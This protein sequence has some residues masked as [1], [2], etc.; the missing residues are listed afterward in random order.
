M[1]ALRRAACLLLALGLLLGCAQ[2]EMQVHQIAAGGCNDS[3]LVTDG[4]TTILVDCGTDTDQH[5]NNQVLL[6]Y[7]AQ[8][9]M[10]HVDVHIVTHYHDDH[11]I[12]IDVL[13][14][15]YGTDDTVLYIPSDEL[16]ERF[17]P[18]PHGTARRMREG[19][20]ADYGAFHLKCVGPEKL[21]YDG[22][23]NRDSLNV[24]ITYGS[25]R[26][27]VTGDYMDGWARKAYPDDIADVEIFSFPHHG[28][29]P[30]CA[31]D[32]TLRAV[33]PYI[34]LVPGNSYSAARK[35]L[36]D[37]WMK[38]DNFY[39]FRSGHVVVTTDGTRESLQVFTEVQPGQFAAIYENAQ[40]SR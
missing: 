12:N 24:V 27:L 4:I 10:T 9:G 31:G 22:S 2:A 7:L 30:I 23:I 14:E 38:G 32:Y 40:P 29:T 1:S 35:K 34:V 8:S 39:S 13:S 21:T 37:L 33:N 15:L 11:A 18:L 16:P 5:L 17:L 28:L 25:V 20:E 6:D 19:D 36:I 3:Y 26:F